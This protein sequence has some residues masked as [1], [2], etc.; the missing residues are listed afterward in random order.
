VGAT[1]RS[2][3]LR[4]QRS[5][6]CDPYVAARY[7]RLEQKFLH[8]LARLQHP[9]KICDGLARPLALSRSGGESEAESR[10]RLR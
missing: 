6:S 4:H 10:Y 8:R 1:E 7:A 5:S 2:F 3:R 9:I